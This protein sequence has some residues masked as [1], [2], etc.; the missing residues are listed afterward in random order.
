[1]VIFYSVLIRADFPLAISRQI[2]FSELPSAAGPAIAQLLQPTAALKM[3]HSVWQNISRFT[4]DDE[5]FHPLIPS[6][7][8]HSAAE[9][10]FSRKKKSNL[11]KTMH[12]CHCGQYLN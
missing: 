5:V 8:K 12:C 6:L 3:N 7:M 2:N 9:C 1:M 10:S 4:A 11:R